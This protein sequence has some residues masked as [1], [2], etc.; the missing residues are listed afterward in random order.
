MID[1][2]EHNVSVAANTLGKT[3][4]ELEIALRNKQK[5]DKVK[6]MFPFVLGICKDILF[7]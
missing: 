1:C 2:I 4:Y 3:V 6:E 7:F 5:A